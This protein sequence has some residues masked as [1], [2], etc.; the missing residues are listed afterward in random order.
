[1]QCTTKEGIKV[2]ISESDYHEGSRWIS[3]LP[4]GSDLPEPQYDLTDAAHV[5]QVDSVEVSE[6]FLIVGYQAHEGG[7]QV[8]VLF[9]HDGDQSFK[10]IFITT[11]W[12]AAEHLR[13]VYKGLGNNWVNYWRYVTAESEDDYTRQELPDSFPYYAFSQFS[14]GAH[15]C[16]NIFLIHKDEPQKVSHY[17][18]N[19][20]FRPWFGD[21][22][23]DGE[24]EMFINDYS[25][26]YWPYSFAAS[27]APRLIL[28][29]TPTGFSLA[30]DLMIK[31]PLDEATLQQKLDEIAAQ[32]DDDS[33]YMEYNVYAAVQEKYVPYELYAT[34]LDLIYSD[35]EKLAW[36]FLEDAWP[37]EISHAWPIGF[38]HK[39]EFLEDLK[40][41][42]CGS[43]FAH[44][45][46]EGFLKFGDKYWF[47]KETCPH[48]YP[49]VEDTKTVFVCE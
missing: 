15:C 18:D 29:I 40:S 45:A 47:L 31:P 2:S 9:I 17:W 34:M 22:N 12:R 35:N 49:E 8:T 11:Q 5:L 30:P 13:Y 33:N 28:R 36:A 41:K 14:L 20:D 27:P 32:I 44:L 7:Q 46:I 42:V 43:L 26:T 4:Y 1:M 23:N 3:Q 37:T 48:L 25:Y 21:A 10:P 38:R 16:F 24:F 39:E 19:L 6:P